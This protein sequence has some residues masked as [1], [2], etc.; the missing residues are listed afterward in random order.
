M[1]ILVIEDNPKM[2]ALIQQGLTEQGYNVDVAHRGH[3][4]HDLA[5]TLAHDLIILDIMLPDIDGFEVCRKLKS[6]D[7]TAAVPVLMLTALSQDENRQKGME[8]GAVDYMTK[9]FD[10]D[11]LMSMIRRH[12]EGK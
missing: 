12:A 10:P 7:E 6:A 2:A 5:A 4:G 1:R 8:C 3:D 9:P 11:Q